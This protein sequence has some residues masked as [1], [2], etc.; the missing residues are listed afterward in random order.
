MKG[1]RKVT[2]ACQTSGHTIPQGGNVYVWTNSGRILFV[3]IARL[4]E[5]GRRPRSTTKSRYVTVET[6]G[7]GITSRQLA[8]VVTVRKQPE[9][10]DCMDVMKTVFR[11]TQDMSGMFETKMP[12]DGVDYSPQF[13][14][15]CPKCSRRRVP[16]ITS[17]PWINGIRVRYHKCACGWQD[18]ST[19]IDPTQ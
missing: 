19:Q 13:G 12:I 4:T 2:S 11:E 6:H 17:R 7:H 15:T 5:K 9:G 8:R 14:A 1:R 3:S 18:K 16:V 10:R